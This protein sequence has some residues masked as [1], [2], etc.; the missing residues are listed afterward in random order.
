MLWEVIVAGE[1]PPFNIA[2]VNALWHRHYPELMRRWN[3]ALENVPSDMFQQVERVRVMNEVLDKLRF[4]VNI[5]PTD[6]PVPP[7]PRNLWPQDLLEG[8]D[9]QIMDD[10][11]ARM[12]N[13]RLGADNV[14]PGTPLGEPGEPVQFEAL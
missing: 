14:P 9:R 6:A 2:E 13:E 12:L 8:I 3:E 1:R 7:A 4:L 11:M 5:L 10:A